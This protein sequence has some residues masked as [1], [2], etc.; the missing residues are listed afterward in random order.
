M[1]SSLP[2]IEAQILDL[3]RRLKAL[4]KQK[5]NLNESEY[6]KTLEQVKSLVGKC[7]KRRDSGRDETRARFLVDGIAFHEDDY[8]EMSL[9]YANHSV[10][11][12]T[13]HYE[14]SHTQ[15]PLKLLKSDYVEVPAQEFDAEVDE[16][17]RAIVS[18][19][20]PSPLC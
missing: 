3:E 12:Q 4:K 16:M 19:R 11:G 14:L 18:S 20:N 2:E 10:L 1:T 6:E 8:F 5:D 9:R 13:L 17:Y 7:F 15:I